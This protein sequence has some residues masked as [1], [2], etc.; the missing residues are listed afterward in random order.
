MEFFSYQNRGYSPDRRSPPGRYHYPGASLI[1]RY[2]PPSL[3]GRYSPPSLQSRY[4]P[5]SL[6][7]RYSPPSPQYLSEY[8]LHNSP[9]HPQY[10][11]LHLPPRY[12]PPREKRYNRSN[13]GYDQRNG[14]PGDFERYIQKCKISSSFKG[15][16]ITEFPIPMEINFWLVYSTS[17]RARLCPWKKLWRKKNSNFLVY[18]TPRQPMSVHKKMPAHSAQP[19]GRLYATYKYE[20]LVFLYGYTDAL[21]VNVICMSYIFFA[22]LFLS[23][24]QWINLKNHSR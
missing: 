19:F 20:C 14:S 12:R 13:M 7:G 6:Q 5:S 17:W 22:S 10:S 24:L 23:V 16:Y 8:S 2:S 15:L 21:Y 3:Q 4:S 1:G 9:S 18:V 11:P